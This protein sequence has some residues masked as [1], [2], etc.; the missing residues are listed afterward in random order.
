MAAT[1]L[2]CPKCAA[3]FPATSARARCPH[4]GAEAA[5]RTR[6]GARAGRPHAEPKAGP[7]RRALLIGLGGTGLLLLVG[8]AVVVALALV[9]GRGKPAAVAEGTPRET[10]RAEDSRPTRPADVVR[11]DDL[12]TPPVKRDPVEAPPPTSLSDAEQQEVNQAIERGIAFLKKNAP[13]GPMGNHRF[14]G[15]HPLVGLTLLECGVPADDIVVANLTKRIRADAKGLG[16][17]YSISLTI[18]FL[19]RLGDAQ[20]EPLIRHL[21][22]RLIA[23][24]NEAGGW[25]Y[26]CPM[27]SEPDAQKLLTYLETNPLS[28]QSPAQPHVVR[29]GDPSR[30]SPAGADEGAKPLLREALPKEVKNRAVVTYQPGKQVRPANIDDNSNTQFAVLGVWA[31]RRHGVPVGRSV[32]LISARFHQS[33]NPDGSWGYD[34]R[35]QTR[36][37]PDSMTCAGLLGLAV[38]RAEGDGEPADKDPAISRGLQFLGKKVG[39]PG[40]VKRPANG[41]P[42]PL[43]IRANALGDLYWLWS[44]ER[45]AVIYSLPTVGGKDWYAWGAGQLVA[46][47]QSDGSWAAGQG[48]VVDTCFALLFLARVNVAKDLTRQLQQMGRIRDPGQ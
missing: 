15:L 45:V 28:I 25:T 6:D 2:V 39:N 41:R 44:L 46:A 40:G 32:G 13:A 7:S 29:P 18:L 23:G 11:G 31:A 8:A 4:C 43:Q 20:D 42:V 38:A 10:A 35:G 37:R 33:Q 21:A 30:A 17:T 26:P 14:S 47:Q 19:D 16:E 22:A 48:P 9:S 27:L 3:R 36:V 34:W 5:R 12:G 1:L 24:Q